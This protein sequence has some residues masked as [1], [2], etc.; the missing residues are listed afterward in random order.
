[1]ERVK[2]TKDFAFVH[3]GTRKAAEKALSS[4]E[5]LRIDGALVEVLWSKPVDKKLYNTR[6]TLTK[7]W[8]KYNVDIVR[9]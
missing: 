1:M 2:K 5:N 7:V 6:K 8:N 4:C 9:Y 3:F